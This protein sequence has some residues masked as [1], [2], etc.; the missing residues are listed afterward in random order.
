MQP[1]FWTRVAQAFKETV[2][3]AFALHGA[4]V[5]DYADGEIDVL[6][7]LD[8]VLVQA[9]FDL[10]IHYDLAQGITFALPAQKKLFAA[11]ALVASG[12]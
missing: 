12:Q 6:P 2:A 10:V 3:H 4:G 8:R 5:H 1:L 11:R 7:W 9:G